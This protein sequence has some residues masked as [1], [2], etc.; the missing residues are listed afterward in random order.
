MMGNDIALIAINHV[1]HDNETV[2]R[3]SLTLRHFIHRT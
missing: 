2:L 1:G 3:E